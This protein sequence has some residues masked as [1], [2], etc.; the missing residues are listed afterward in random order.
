MLRERK[1]KPVDLDG[2]KVLDAVEKAH[3]GSPDA[4]GEF[5]FAS[6]AEML[7]HIERGRA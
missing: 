5:K 1:S 2:L 4:I 6:N 7:A 3:A